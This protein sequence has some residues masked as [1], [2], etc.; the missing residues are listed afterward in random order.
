[1]TLQSEIQ[2]GEIKQEPYHQFDPLC[3]QMCEYDPSQV[4]VFLHPPRFT[5]I[6]K[7]NSQMPYKLQALHDRRMSNSMFNPLN[8]FGTKQ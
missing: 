8:N 5:K 3:S 2:I 7:E 1:M 6:S 4:N